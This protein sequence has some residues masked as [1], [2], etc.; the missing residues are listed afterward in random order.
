MNARKLGVHTQ[1]SHIYSCKRFAAFLKR[2]PDTATPDDVR[3]FQLHLAESWR[4]GYGCG[5]RTSEV[6]RLRV[7]HID[8]AQKIIRIEQSKGPQG[9]QRHAV[10]Q[11]ARSLAAIMEDRRGFDD[12]A[13]SRTLAVSWS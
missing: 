10:A 13:P 6:V 11:D 7:K 4:V 2:S 3:R 1:R 9:S 12:N 5:L 8:S